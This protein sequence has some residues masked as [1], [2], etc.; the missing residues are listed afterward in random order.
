MLFRYFQEFADVHSLIFIPTIAPGHD[1]SRTELVNGTQPLL[2]ARNEGKYYISAWFQVM[3]SRAKYV[4]INSFNDWNE[5]TQIE[6][7]KRYQDSE[8][9]FEGYGEKGENSYL[10]ITKEWA[11]IMV[12]RWHRRSL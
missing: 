1:D 6:P 3:V 5:G 7:A 4:S 8:M 10:D 12:E 9:T 2:F 11:D